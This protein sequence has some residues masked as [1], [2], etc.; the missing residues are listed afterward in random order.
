M[1]ATPTPFPGV[2]S[3]VCDGCRAKISVEAANLDDA[4]ERL[5][6]K[7]W[8]EVVRRGTGIR[9]WLWLC[10]ECSANN[11]KAKSRER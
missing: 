9:K 2:A 3:A 11:A 5:K 4:R 6:A 8:Y 1:L 7:N 10:P